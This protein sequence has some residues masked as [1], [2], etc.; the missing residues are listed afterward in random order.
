[1]ANLMIQREK[2]QKHFRFCVQIRA[3]CC[4]PLMYRLSFVQC[5]NMPARIHLKLQLMQ[6][7]NATFAN[8]SANNSIAT[9]CGD[10]MHAKEF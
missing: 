10:T 3:M 7:F 9:K 4:S 8:G 5:T 1:M 2:A 6:Q